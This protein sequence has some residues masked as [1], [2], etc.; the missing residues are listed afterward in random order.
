MPGPSWDRLSRFECWCECWRHNDLLQAGSEPQWRLSEN[1]C[2]WENKPDPASL[3]CRRK[4][5][6][7]AKLILM[8]DEPQEQKPLPIWER[9]LGRPSIGFLFGLG[10][11]V[12]T[13]LTWYFYPKV[14]PTYRVW[15]VETVAKRESPRLTV[16]WDG[17][18]IENLCIC[19]IALWNNGKEPITQD[20]LPNSDPLRIVSNDVHILAIETANSSRQTLTFD[21]K[22]AEHADSVHIAIDGGDAMEK[23]DGAVFRILFTGNCKSAFTVAGR[24][25]GSAGF[26]LVRAGTSYLQSVLALFWGIARIFLCGIFY[27]SHCGSLSSMGWC[28]NGSGAN[29]YL[30]LHGRWIL[31]VQMASRRPLFRLASTM[32]ESRQ[33]YPTLFTSFAVKTFDTDFRI[34][35]QTHRS[36]DLPR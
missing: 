3:I 34:K 15:P 18:P 19:R 22:I 7:G 13:L 24:V 30:H 25:I 12:A 11:I 29:H 4:V 6:I 8:P 32:S 26:Q 16:E 9:F 36:R 28:F 23:G 21:T 27:P 33:I 10:G 17:K 5:F 2:F 20:K 14:D 31:A 35:R 1:E